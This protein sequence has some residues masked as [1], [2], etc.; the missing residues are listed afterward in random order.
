MILM[1]AGLSNEYVE[2]NGIKVSALSKL[3]NEW[4]TEFIFGFIGVLFGGAFTAIY[5]FVKR[6][7]FK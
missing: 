6:S 4:Q 7:T 3:F 5:S 2:N 1:V